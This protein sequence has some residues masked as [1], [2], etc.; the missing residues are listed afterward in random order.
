MVPDEI[1]ALQLLAASTYVTYPFVLT[2]LVE[3]DESQKTF[4][5][6]LDTQVNDRDSHQP[7]NLAISWDGSFDDVEFLKTH[8]ERLLY[9]R[10]CIKAFFLH[11]M[12]ENLY[13]QG[14]RPFDPHVKSKFQ[15]DYFPVKEFDKD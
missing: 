2:P 1:R 4:T 7:M 6:V 14:D 13:V 10:D 11:E 12:D 9:L 3:V 15:Q 5:I 8:E